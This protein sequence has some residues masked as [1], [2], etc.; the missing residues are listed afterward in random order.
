MRSKKWFV[1]IGLVLAFVLVV[2][3][4]AGQK[5]P[6]PAPT[7]APAAQPTPT[8][9]AEEMDPISKLDPS[10][11]EV[12]FWHVSTRKHEKVLMEIID[13]F[14]S[15]NPYGIKVVPEYAGYYGD[16]YKKILA[17]IAAG[18]TPDMAIGYANQV[19]EYAKAG[20][21]VPLDP[22]MNS[23]KYGFSEEEKKDFMWNL[24]EGDKR[25]EFG[26]QYMSFAHSRSMQ[27]MYYNVDWLKE[28]GYDGPPKTWDEFKE[29]CMK[30]TD[31]AKGTHGYAYSGSASLFATL[32]FTFGGDIVTK[33]NQK[34]AFN[35]EAGLKALQLLKELFDS[36]CA[37]EVAERYGDQKDFANRKALFTFGSTAGLPYY[38]SAIESSEAGP[39]QWDVAAPPTAIGKPVVN[40]Y[41]PSAAIFKSVPER[42]LAGWLFFKY[43]AEPKNVAK[44]AMVA[45]YFPIRKSA[46]ELPEMQEYM[47]KNPQYKKAF[48]LLPYGRMEPSVAGYQQIRG[49]IAD[50]MKK[51]IEG[52]DPQQVLEAAAQEAQGVLD[53]NK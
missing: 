20:V 26:G 28:L 4:C 36:G 7:K 43:W 44:W 39:F 38:R 31:P 25:P 11:Q 1:L 10:G 9:A 52:G 2:A 21:I 49:I 5:T 22:F 12:L 14:N 6:T 29:M 17:G 8:K 47:K 15:S 42:E 41:G 19:A 34:V 30:A 45:N 18:E 16:I 53:Q 33:D 40:V 23:K 24:L 27:V 32:V 35:G 50:A 37:Y 51:V 46:I 13:G 3:A 48:D